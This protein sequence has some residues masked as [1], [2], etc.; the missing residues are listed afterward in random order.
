MTPESLA[1]LVGGDAEAPGEACVAS[2]RR[3]RTHTDAAIESTVSVVV[4]SARRAASIRTPATYWAGLVPTSAAKQRVKWRSLM[5][6]RGR[7]VA[8]AVVASG[9]GVDE[10][11]SG[12]NRCRVGSLAPDRRGELG[13]PTGAAQEHHQ[14]PGD[15]LGDLRIVVVL[16]QRQRQVDAG[17]DAG[18]R[19]QIAVTNED[20]L[21]IDVDVGELTLEGRRSRPVGRHP[22][23]VGEPGGGDH[24]RPGAHRDDPVGATPESADSVD[25]RRI[26]SGP[27]R[28]EAAGDDQRVR[29]PGGVG[30]VPR[31]EREPALGLDRGFGCDERQAIAGS[32]RTGSRRAPGWP[33]GTLPT[34]RSGRGPGS[35][36]RR[37][38][39]TSSGLRRVGTSPSWRARTVW[40]Q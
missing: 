22:L 12:A 25:Q 32:V 20:R 4:S 5:P 7:E 2:S 39:P 10:I 1:V 24:E 14:P 38:T 23:A 37:R 21:G 8:D 34:D 33:R 9:L 17:G 18:G 36:R 15:H 30:H 6:T 13:L 11:L 31:R 26:L 28:A 27:P 29:P 16:D 35:R 40:R 3:C 19:P